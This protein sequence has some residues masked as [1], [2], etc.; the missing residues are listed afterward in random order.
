MKLFVIC[1]GFSRPHIER[2][3]NKL[4]WLGFQ[5]T[6]HQITGHCDWFGEATNLANVSTWRFFSA[7]P[8]FDLQSEAIH[9]HSSVTIEKSSKHAELQ[10]V[11]QRSIGGQP[12]IYFASK[13]DQLIIS[14]SFD[15]CVAGAEWCRDIDELGCAARFSGRS[16]EVLGRTVVRGTHSLPPGYRLHWKLNHGISLERYWDFPKLNNEFLKQNSTRQIQRQT[17]ALADNLYK[18]ISISLAELD[19]F[20]HRCLFFSGGLDSSALFAILQRETKQPFELRSLYSA[21]SS[22]FLR[23]S[24][25]ALESTKAYSDIPTKIIRGRGELKK[26]SSP[27]MNTLVSPVHL[28]DQWLAT[29]PLSSRDVAIRGEFADELLGGQRVAGDWARELDFS[30]LIQAKHRKRFGWRTPFKWFEYRKRMHPEPPPHPWLR[31]DLRW[32]LTC[33]STRHPILSDRP[34]LEHHYQCTDWIGMDEELSARQGFAWCYPFRTR[35]LLEV[36]ASIPAR[37]LME[38]QAKTIL[39]AAVNQALPPRLRE[40]TD[41]DHCPLDPPLLKAETPPLLS[42]ANQQNINI[43]AFLPLFSP[44]A[45]QGTALLSAASLRHRKISPTQ[46]LTAQL[47]EETAVLIQEEL[48]A[49]GLLALAH[50]LAEWRA[51]EVAEGAL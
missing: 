11:I 32:S 44:V 14:N 42:A 15:A 29:D 27:I 50:Y 31:A 39:R 37:G 5:H 34:E 17:E 28:C 19:K 10:I 6:G 38:K 2:F 45:R 18:N 43:E 26:L 49:S 3:K 7:A 46:L 22:E 48:R 23:D 1:H 41:K 9:D 12:S 8:Q 16:S 33:A 24:T 20:H 51:A 13:N 21:N 36:F 35:G 47:T 40:R 25:Y 30:E 4:A